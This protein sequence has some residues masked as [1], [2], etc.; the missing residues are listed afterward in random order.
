MRNINDCYLHLGD[1]DPSAYNAKYAVFDKQ[2][3]RLFEGMFL[4]EK[5]DGADVPDVPDDPDDPDD[6][7]VPDIP[8]GPVEP[9]GQPISFGGVTVEGIF[10]EGTQLEIEKYSPSPAV[11]AKILESASK[12]LG[13]SESKDAVKNFMVY[14]GD[15]H[16]ILDGQPSSAQSMV[17]VWIPIDWKNSFKKAFG[18]K[19]SE[20]EKLYAVIAH[21]TDDGYDVRAVEIS[22]AVGSLA[23]GKYGLDVYRNGYGFGC[24]IFEGKS[25]IGSD[26]SDMSPFIVYLILESTE[27]ASEDDDISTILFIACGIFGLCLVAFAVL[28]AVTLIKRKKKAEQ[29]PA[30]VE[31]VI[32]PKHAK[33]II[34]PGSEDAVMPTYSDEDVNEEGDIYPLPHQ[35]R[36]PREDE[37]PDGV[38]AKT[39]SVPEDNDPTAEIKLGEEKQDAAIP[40]ED[41]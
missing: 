20:G 8:V 33:K 6:P 41:R 37:L 12:M 34:D 39:A 31:T 13:I 27:G 29:I 24:E 9:V 35:L 36:D 15:I 3:E 32:A 40:E 22:D 28:T 30:A 14:S 17:K 18:G 4:F 1:D 11:S 26:Y 7:D 25:Q 16:L 10:A 2:G 21:V 38:N 23:S 5:E 19:L